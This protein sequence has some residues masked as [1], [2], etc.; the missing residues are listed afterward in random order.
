M[1]ISVIIPAYNEEKYIGKTL[2]SIKD[3]D[4]NGY[5]VEII[6]VNGGSTDK[7][8]E[9]AKSYGARVL[10]EPHRGI[11]FARQ[12][13]LLVAEGDIVAFTDADTIVPKDWLIKL[14]EALQRPGWYMRMVLSGYRT[15]NF[16]INS[17][18]IISS[19][20]YYGYSIIFSTNPLPPGKTMLFGG[21]R[22]YL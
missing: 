21:K 11:G 5:E 3:A 20:I 19:R 1:R 4:K 13:G 9:V 18:S 2:Q 15:E 22:L 7:T 16:L 17:I 12:Q 8:E 10:N 6:V 14:V